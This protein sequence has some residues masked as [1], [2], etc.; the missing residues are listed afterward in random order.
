MATWARLSLTTPCPCPQGVTTMTTRPDNCCRLH[1]PSVKGYQSNKFMKDRL[2]LSTKTVR[3]LSVRSRQQSQ[4]RWV[5]GPSI[6]MCMDTPRSQRL[7]YLH[8]I[9]RPHI[10]PVR[11]KLGPQEAVCKGTDWD[12]SGSHP[13]APRSYH[14]D[15]LHISTLSRRCALDVQIVS[16]TEHLVTLMLHSLCH[17]STLGV[18]EQT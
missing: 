3:R 8:N 9:C 5:E 4:E 15:I 2:T 6:M 17:V 14:R 18:S 11:G 1:S 12:S 13:S 16:T 7:V 10:H